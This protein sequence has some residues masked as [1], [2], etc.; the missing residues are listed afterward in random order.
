M[1]TAACPQCNDN[2]SIPPEASAEAEVQC[3]LCKET[4]FLSEMLEKLPPALIILDDPAAQTF[5]S[6]SE[7]SAFA[8]TAG[9]KAEHNNLAT[10]ID[11][12]IAE[13]SA[14]GSSESQPRTHVPAGSSSAKLTTSTR[15]RRKQNSL[16]KE[17][18]KVLMGGIIGISLGQLILWWIPI[19]SLGIHQRD[20]ANIG[21][22]LANIPPFTYIIPASVREHASSGTSNTDNLNRSHEPATPEAN[23]HGDIPTLSGLS[24]PT[25]E[26]PNINI[27]EPQPS[28]G[29]QDLED[30]AENQTTPGQDTVGRN[31]QPATI[32]APEIGIAK[33]GDDRKA[34]DT[35]NPP[36][37]ENLRLV[38]V[39][40]A[41]TMLP[42]DLRNALR[43]VRSAGQN[44]RELGRNA[45]ISQK[46]KSLSKLYEALALVGHVVTFLDPNEQE[47]INL[48]ED[49]ITWM[50]DF[51]NDTKTVQALGSWSTRWL[52][53]TDRKN[54]GI[55]LFGDVTAIQQQGTFFEISLEVSIPKQK[56]KTL[57]IVSAIDPSLIINVGEP[58]IAFG[59][60]VEQ[61]LENLGGYQGTADLVVFLGYP[62]PAHENTQR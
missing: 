23:A 31:T 42:T 45:S 30:P 21:R 46:R 10:E 37:E 16:A 54:E 48:Q 8:I 19:S 24:A 50:E 20:P 4:F 51:R 56:P 22:E 34:S 28:Q 57:S 25:T 6:P 27:N 1:T 44:W 17:G 58:L 18:F 61:P 49:L 9:E 3:P 60:I 7:V 14:F 32:N 11:L 47:S 62:L 33:I 2:V 38:G 55:F 13:S 36:S 40:D 39:I 29:K 59:S 12:N 35:N 52:D 5:Q 15:P 26:T 41:P 53:Q 43:L